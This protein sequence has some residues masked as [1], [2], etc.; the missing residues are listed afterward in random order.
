YCKSLAYGMGQLRRDWGASA[1]NTQVGVAEVRRH[2]PAPAADVVAPGEE[3]PQDLHR[4][5]TNRHGDGDVAVVREDPVDARPKRESG[6]DLR[7]LVAFA[8]E[9]HRPLAHALEHPLANT[10]RASK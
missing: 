10:E 4:R 1:D 5:H 9:C 2:V 6:A 8:A 3:P 7:R